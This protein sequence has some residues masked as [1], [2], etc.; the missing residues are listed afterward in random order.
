[1]IFRAGEPMNAADEP[2]REPHSWNL[3]RPAGVATAH[4]PP[5]ALSAELLELADQIDSPFPSPLGHSARHTSALDEP[6]Q[7][8]DQP[9]DAPPS[10]AAQSETN[11]ITPHPVDQPP[12]PQQKTSPAYPSDDAKAP[13]A[14]PLN[15][16][17]EQAS[18]PANLLG[19]ASPWHEK[20]WGK[21][22][23][24]HNSPAADIELI[25]AL[26]LL[27]LGTGRATLS[28]RHGQC[29]ATLVS[30]IIF[31]SKEK[32]GFKPR[33]LFDNDLIASVGSVYLLRLAGATTPLA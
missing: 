5:D 28:R 2:H 15:A 22:I 17:D 11:K 4:A 7:N 3:F 16:S 33:E 27:D 19:T 10:E 23:A 18:H 29:Y 30:G 13:G 14:A 24:M 6:A 8:H 9:P 25:A 20:T 32:L 26:A 1:M 31:C 12:F 21:L